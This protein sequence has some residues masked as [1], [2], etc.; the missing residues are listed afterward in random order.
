[1]QKKYAAQ[2]PQTKIQRAQGP[3]RSKVH[4]A[5]ESAQKK[6]TKIPIQSAQMEQESKHDRVVYCDAHVEGNGQ[7][8]RTKK[9]KLK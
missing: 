5:L 4:T 8:L 3:S 9:G 1:M 2:L 7:W 6:K